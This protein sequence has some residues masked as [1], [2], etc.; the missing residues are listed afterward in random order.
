MTEPI[1]VHATPTAAQIAAALRQIITALGSIVGALG[2]AGLFESKLN[3]ALS[4]I[5][6]ASAV[7]AI[8]WG[9][10]ATRADA[11]KAATMAAALPDTVAQ[12]K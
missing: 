11:K 9:Q 8:A 4:L 3:L 5:G 12:L 1:Q 10:V 2:Y 6:P 7:L